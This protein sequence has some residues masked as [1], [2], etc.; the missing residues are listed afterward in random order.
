VRPVILN[1]IRSAFSF[2]SAP[3]LTQNTVSSPRPANFTSFA[4]ARSRIAIGSAFVWNASCRAWR[5]SA[6]CQRG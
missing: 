6:A 2:A 5:S 1:A 4:A 3:L